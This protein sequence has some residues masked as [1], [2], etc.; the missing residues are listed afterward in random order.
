MD[1]QS[2]VDYLAHKGILQEQNI[3]KIIEIYN[4]I[5]ENDLRGFQMNNQ[6]SL[7]DEFDDISQGQ[8]AVELQFIFA[9][10]DYLKLTAQDTESGL[11]DVAQS[12]F[13]SWKS[14]QE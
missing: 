4:D 7:N 8:Q 12:I 6:S 10:A 3:V 9:L 2:F 13:E 11:F 5:D 14:Q 1:F